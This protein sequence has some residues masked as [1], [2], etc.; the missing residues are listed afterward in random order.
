[1]IRTLVKDKTNAI[2]IGKLWFVQ[3]HDKDAKIIWITDMLGHKKN[4]ISKLISK[5]DITALSKINHI[6]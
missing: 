4:E 2:Y 6:H 3:T 1:M 5:K